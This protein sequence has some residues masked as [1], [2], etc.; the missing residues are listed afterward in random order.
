MCCQKSEDTQSE[1]N[2]NTSNYVLGKNRNPESNR[3]VVFFFIKMF[4]T[5]PAYYSGPDNGDQIKTTF[6]STRVVH[7]VFGQVV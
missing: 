1:P 4:R 5:A 7:K 2:K 3:K 6:F